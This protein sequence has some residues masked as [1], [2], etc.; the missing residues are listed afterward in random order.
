MSDFECVAVPR[1]INEVFSKIAERKQKYNERWTVWVNFME[2][3]NE[4]IYDLLEETHKQQGE[5][6]PVRTSVR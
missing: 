6:R 3:Y 1:V 2:I 5:S 4:S